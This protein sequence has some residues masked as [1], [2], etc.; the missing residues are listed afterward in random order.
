[1]EI[2]YSFTATGAKESFDKYLLPQAQEKLHCLQI[3][4]STGDA[5]MYLL[6]HVLSNSSSTLTDVDTWRGSG[7]VEEVGI[8]W[9]EVEKQYDSHHQN[10][11]AIGRL[12]KCKESTNAFFDRNT[13]IFDFIYVDGNL[14]GPELLQYG[15]SA[16]RCLAPQ[17]LLAIN[18]SAWRQKNSPTPGP[19][20]AVSALIDVYSDQVSVLEANNLVW[21]RRN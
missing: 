4:V 11:I 2:P 15:M 10:E 5:T 17:G 21:M 1:M 19:S 9:S 3:G 14:S 6:Q 12:I 20:P 8:R 18:D 16:I 13:Q 7:I